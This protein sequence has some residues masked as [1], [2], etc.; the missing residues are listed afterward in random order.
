MA[1]TKEKKA[2]IVSWLKDKLQKAAS[3]IFVNFRGLTVARLTELRR[4]LKA[5][6]AGFTVVKKTLLRLA[7]AGQK[8][9]GEPPSLEGEVALTYLDAGG[10]DPIAVAR[11]LREFAKKYKD[12]IRLL[13][14]IFEGRYVAPEFMQYLA[15][16]PP[17]PTLYGQLVCLL[18]SPLRRL[19][20]VLDQISKK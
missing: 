2:Q 13:G 11:S 20:V 8:A 1:I 4:Q 15:A 9:T 16:I 10:G 19:A 7:L 5:Q 12:S 18:S 14:G 3:V 17:R 6:S